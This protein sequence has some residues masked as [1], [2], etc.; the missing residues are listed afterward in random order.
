MGHRRIIKGACVI[1]MDPDI[2]ILERGDILIEGEKILEVA[3]DLDVEDAELIDGT[4]TIAIPGLIDTH[5]HL[6]HTQLRTTGA[7]DTNFT[8]MMNFVLGYLA[9]YRAEDVFIGTLAGALEAL[10]AGVTTVVDFADCMLS[11]D[12]A[13]ESVRAHQESGIR[14]VLCYGLQ[15][16]PKIE[17]GKPADLDNLFTAPEML[18]HDARRI[19]ETRLPSDDGLVTMGLSASSLEGQPLER[20]RS[21]LELGRELGLRTIT[22]HA[23]VG[24]LSGDKHLVQDLGEAGL[25]GADILISHGN[26]LLDSELE[27][28]AQAGASIAAS[29]ENEMSDGWPSVTGRALEKGVQ[30]SL[31]ADSVTYVSGDMFRQIRYAL[32]FERAQVGRDLN[33]RGVVMPTMPIKTD[34]GLELATIGGARAIGLDHL[35]GS[36]TP[37]KQADIALIRFDHLSF[38]PVNDPVKTLVMMAS[39]GDVDTVFVAGSPVKREGRLLREDLPAV[40]KGLEASRDHLEDTVKAMDL[41]QVRAQ[42]AA[43]YSLE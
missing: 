34:V 27:L 13:D 37:G 35:I 22:A 42:I 26:G 3:P 43:T 19:R 41:E 11:P 12:H 25:L 18:F 7:D 5:R 23:A 40:F 2:G 6:S 38:A 10:E 9:A 30:V 29:P 31:G 15:G 33:A 39:A 28:M 32:H 16:G 8:Y 21:Q 24:S 17:S 1:T 4:G 20:A 36:I 14:S